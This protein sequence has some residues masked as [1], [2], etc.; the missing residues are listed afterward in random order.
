[1]RQLTL[2]DVVAV[3]VWESEAMKE[4]SE[5]MRTKSNGQGSISRIQM[6]ICRVDEEVSLADRTWKGKWY[7]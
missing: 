4:D 7:L 3:V 6:I 5:G 1:M 2:S